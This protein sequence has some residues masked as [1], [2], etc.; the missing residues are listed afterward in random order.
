M[1]LYKSGLGGGMHSAEC[2]SNWLYDHV[3]LSKSI[4]TGYVKVLFQPYY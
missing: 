3:R 4:M 1:S 2:L